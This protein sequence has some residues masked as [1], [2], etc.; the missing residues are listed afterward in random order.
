LCVLGCFV[1]NTCRSTIIFD[2]LMN[3]II[4]SVLWFKYCSNQHKT[5][6]YCKYTLI[7]V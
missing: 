3:Q 4:T 5:S 1:Q 7:P 6:L 2:S